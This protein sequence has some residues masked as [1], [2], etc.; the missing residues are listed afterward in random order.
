MK[1]R[2]EPYPQALTLP[3]RANGFA[4]VGGY[5][6]NPRNRHSHCHRDQSD[7]P[8]VFYPPRARRIP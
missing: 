4:T 6:F 8:H 7:I 3:E 2:K 5:R 1:R